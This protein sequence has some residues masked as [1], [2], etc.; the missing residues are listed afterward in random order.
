MVTVTQPRRISTGL[1]VALLAVP[2]LAA[3]QVADPK[4]DFADA[5]AQFSLAL[6]GAYGDE[7]PRILSSLESM[8]RGLA[9]WDETI[10]DYEMG[11][12]A[13]TKGVEPKLAA[14]AHL[15][16]GGIYLDRSRTADALREFTTAGALDPDRADAYALQG[17]ASSQS[18]PNSAA[19]VQ[20]FQKASALDPTDVVR[21]YLLARQLV[22][23][24]KTDEASSAFRLVL[25]NQKRHA[26]ERTVAVTTHFMRFGIVEE[27]TG[28]EPFF[29][30]AAYA[31]GFTLLARGEY[32]PAIVSLRAS[33]ARDVLV[34]DQANRYGMRR[35]ADAFRQASLET[36]VQQLEAAI[37]LAPDRAEP[38]RILGLVYAADEQYDRGIAELRKA[39]SLG[40]DDERA[41]LALADTLVRAEQYPAA[42]QALRE[43]IARLPRSGRAHYT[44]AR[45][46]QR[47][48]KDMEAVQEFTTAVTF[49]P[50]LGLNGIYQAMGAISAAR[51]NFD[52]AIDAYTKR[53]ELHPNDADAHQDLGETN[54]RLGR[55]DEALAEFAVAL[56]IN[57]EKTE[58]H[59]SV[60]QV[61]LGQSQYVESAEAARRALDL[62][63]SH[64][65]ARYVLAT[66]LIR[67]G[68][69]DEGQR[70]LN[71]FQRL[72]AL[73]AAAHARD[74]EL[75]GLRREAS[76]SSEN[77]DH[78][79]AVV[80][81]RKALE[82]EPDAAVSHVNLGLALLR[83]G[84]PAEAVTRFQAAAALNAPA[85]LVD[86]HRYLAEAY[87][88]LGR[89]EESRRELAVYEQLRH[90]RLQRGGAAR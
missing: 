78:E 22:R 13:E 89:D 8:E 57:P 88:A 4:T 36:A 43:T 38:H 34:A 33:A 56:T 83:A 52:A 44:L 66:S 64:R 50:L 30:P 45:L 80:L 63:P 20:A 65:Q 26:G 68:R 53:V 29:P 74:F 77:G 61:Y 71:E 76:I 31:E 58:T 15:A 47:Q 17:L 62:D 75:G 81:L 7:G 85:P 84:Q 19:A 27:K 42:E 40:P 72:Q 54:A 21:A 69:T 6:D 16:L 46:Y 41:R 55:I 37:E 18:S 12:A 70:E 90:E 28:V 39:V 59:A 32:A 11:V 79:K 49:G 51:Q 86:V 5:L 9:K 23:A 3:G 87:S 2:N 1:L 35:A 67:L 73:D 14:L 24:G 60:A 10:R 48:G 82:L 25:V